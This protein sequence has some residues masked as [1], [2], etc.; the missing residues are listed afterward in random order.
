[1]KGF[2]LA[3]FVCFWFL[4]PGTLYAQGERKY[5]RQG[6]KEYFDDAYDQ[7]EISVRFIIISETHCFSQEK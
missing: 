5:I 4:I 2:L 7:S 6:N 3:F 1:M